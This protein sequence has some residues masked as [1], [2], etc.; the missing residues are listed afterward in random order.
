MTTTLQL[1]QQT[2]NTYDFELEVDGL[3]STEITAWLIIKTKG[4]E[5]SFPCT[6]AGT[7]F[8]CKIP[9]LPF[10]ERTA[11]SGCIRLVADDYFFEPV[12]NIIVNVTGNLSF[13]PTDIKNMTLKSGVDD[14]KVVD[15]KP[16]TDAKPATPKTVA[17]PV[18]SKK[19]KSALAE[20]LKKSD[21]F[22]VTSKVARHDDLNE[23]VEP[24]KPK[25]DQSEMQNIL[26]GLTSK[27]KS[28]K[29]RARFKRKPR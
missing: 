23:S 10:I 16:K 28:K 26:Q 24:K 4:V 17:K 18:A 14:K 21:S 27:S 6:Q 2:E 12:N 8:S 13:E 29:P 25:I 5:L 3:T 11:Y 7:H 1:N 19:P 9:P 22:K 20:S 15:D